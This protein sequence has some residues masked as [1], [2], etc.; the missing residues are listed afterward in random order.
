MTFACP[1][2]R[3]MVWGSTKRALRDGAL[4]IGI[5]PERDAFG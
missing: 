5:Q 3:R 4:N 2:S 1:D